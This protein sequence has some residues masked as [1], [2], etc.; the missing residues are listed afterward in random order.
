[1]AKQ[2]DALSGEKTL[3]ATRSGGPGTG[4]LYDLDT[5]LCV[6][7]RVSSG[8]AATF[9]RWAG[10]ILRASAVDGFAINEARMRDDPAAVDRLAA[11]LRGLRA[12]ET[13]IYDTVRAFFREAAADHDEDSAA[14][15]A[16]RTMLQDK[17]IFAVTGKLPSDV[18]LQRADH[19]APHMGL[20]RFAGDLPS[21]DDA[22][23]AANYLDG[24]ELFI[25]HILCEQFL[26]YIQG[27]AARGRTM[28][29]RE[30]GTKLDDL[31]RLDEVPVLPGHK[32]LHRDRAVRHAQAEYARFNPARREAPPA[33]LR[34]P[35]DL[36]RPA[37]PRA[38]RRPLTLPG[39]DNGPKRPARAGDLRQCASPSSVSGYV[40][41]VSGACFADFGHFVTCVDNDPAKIDMLRHGEMP[42]Y[43]PGLADLVASNVRSHRLAFSPDLAPA[44]SSAEVVLIAVG[45]PSRRGDGHADLSYVYGAA[46]EIAAAVTGPTVVVTKS[47]VP[48]G[49]GDEVE[50]ILRDTRPDIAWSVVSNPEFLREGAAIEDFKRPDRIVLGTEDGRARTVMQEL[51]PAALPEP[52]PPSSGRRVARPN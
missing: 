23:M 46:R 12:D 48:V 19:H 3:E 16:F 52:G 17:F 18:I 10:Q 6:G 28:T 44:V 42:I 29:M 30:L 39:R 5:I 36:D 2:L 34:S 21:V 37:A 13:N 51:L 4:E 9:R 40:G 20:Q 50:R 25:L 14:A 1:M 41:L 47:T 45:T 11:R 35:P 7:Y 15:R 32:D 38:G 33:R 43:E 24:D 8:K 31:L 49:T 22:R 27:K 26:L